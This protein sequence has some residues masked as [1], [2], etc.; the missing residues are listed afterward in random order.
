[1]ATGYLSWSLAQSDF[2]NPNNYMSLSNIYNN[3][4]K[5]M[6]DVIID[7]ENESLKKIT[8]TIHEKFF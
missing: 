2:K 5:D 8:E 1:M 3:F 7:G 4:M 6:P